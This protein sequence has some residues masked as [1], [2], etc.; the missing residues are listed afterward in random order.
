MSILRDLIPELGGCKITYYLDSENFPYGNLG[1]DQ[2]KRRGEEISLIL[3]ERGTGIQVVACNTAT[4]QTISHLRQQFDLPFIGVEPFLN[5]I[6]ILEH[7]I[8]SDQVACI[9]T[10]ATARSP[11]FLSL[12]QQRDPLNR[13]TML[14]APNLASAIE[15]YFLNG[16][17]EK[18]L[19]LI[20]NIF[21]DLGLATY[22]YLIL[23]CTH[24]PLIQDLFEKHLGVKCLTPNLGVKMQL[25]RILKREYPHFESAPWKKPDIDYISSGPW[26]GEQLEDLLNSLTNSIPAYQHVGKSQSSWSNTVLDLF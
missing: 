5:S 11:Q 20:L 1:G 17:S 14:P 23:G 16:K 19:K 18:D 21:N 12:L 9:V 15:D 10:E 4:S 25:L 24:Y 3:Q 13:I 26:T 8:H 2:I 22:D 6:N 7:E